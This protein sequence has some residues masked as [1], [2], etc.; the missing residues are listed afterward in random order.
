MITLNVRLA[1]TVCAAMLLLAAGTVEAAEVQPATLPPTVSGSPVTSPATAA[2]PSTLESFNAAMHGFNLWVWD[3]VDSAGAWMGF[4]P[5]PAAVSS[6]VSNALSNLINEPTSAISWVVAGDYGN[7]FTAIRRFWINT[8]QGWL[9]IEDVATAQGIVAPPIDIGLALC[10]RGVGEGAY[11]VMPF[12]GPRTLRDGLSDF[13]LVNT[14]TY[15][16]LAPV[17][18]FPPSLQSLATVE[19]VE[20]AGR[21]AV[22]RQ[23]DHGDDRNP[24]ADAVRDQYLKSRRERCNQTIA[25]M[26]AKDTR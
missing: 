25:L 11:V 17:I 2:A 13:L 3:E 15:L 1:I 23:I 26:N 16:T 7:A 9:G 6:S 24:S 4:L 19:V 5:P 8:T 18:G 12:V 22:M 10:T 20:E 14:I 21:V